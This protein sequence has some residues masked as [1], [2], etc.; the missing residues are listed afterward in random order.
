MM[1]FQEL[2]AVESFLITCV[3][4]FQPFSADRGILRQLICKVMPQ[5]GPSCVVAY[6]YH[7]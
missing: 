1:C 5:H 2:S 3:K 6:V 4:E 7:K